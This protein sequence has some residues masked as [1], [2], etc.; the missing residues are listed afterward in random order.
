MQ[1]PKTGNPENPPFYAYTH[2]RSDGNRFVSGRGSLQRAAPVDIPLAGVP[3]WL[4]AAPFGAGVLWVAVLEDGRVQGFLVIGKAVSEQPITPKRLPPG[5][6]PV[7]KVVDGQ[8]E[9][10]TPSGAAASPLTP[11][12][13]LQPNGGIAYLEAGGGLVLSDGPS[14]RLPVNALPD[15]RLL[16]GE[17]NRLLVL[18]GPT[19]IYSHGVLGDA[20]EAGGFTLVQVYPEL[21]IESTVGLT[22]EVIEGLAAIWT[23]LDGDGTRE[24]LV[25]ASN[26]DRGAR[27]LVFDEAG[28]QIAA[29]P[30]GG[31]GLRWRHQLAAAPFG[32]GGEMEI[33]DVLTP[34]IGGVV[35]FFRLEGKELRLVAEIPG[36]RS[37]RIGSRNLDMGLAGDFDGDGSVELAVPTQDLSQLGFIRRTQDASSGAE[38]AWTLPIGGTAATNIAAATEKDGRIT[39]GIGREDN[40]LRVWTPP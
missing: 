21:K 38:V 39:L 5:M 33:V 10:L 1:P 24:I 15:A 8:A 3:R 16:T 9:L 17:N 23:D 28:N 12:A 30:A 27:L 18:T 14:S 29:G 11:P 31:S 2:H 40:V 34:H 35:E 37:H 22:G 4:V 36:F 20:I 6:P 32:P 13:V 26:V 25:T 19:T 7:L